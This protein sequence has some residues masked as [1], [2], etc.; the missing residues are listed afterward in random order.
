[1]AQEL[2]RR[3]AIGVPGFSVVSPEAEKDRT[4]AKKI[5]NEAKIEGNM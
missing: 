4:M 1:M 2:T 3:G 5:L